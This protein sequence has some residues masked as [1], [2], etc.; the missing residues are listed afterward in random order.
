MPLKRMLEGG[1]F[2]PKA[3][4]ILL[5]AFD[6]IVAELDLKAVA[7]RERAAKIVIGLAAGKATLDATKL[8]DEAVD[9]M[10]NES[11]DVHGHDLNQLG[12]LRGRHGDPAGGRRG[13]G[14]PD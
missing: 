13:A 14:A 8:R 6:G 5:E 2:D 7:D 10:R 3:V 11:V 1:N 9:L 12:G 4:A